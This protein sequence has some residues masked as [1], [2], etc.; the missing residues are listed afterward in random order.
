[1]ATPTQTLNSSDFLKL[2]EMIKTQFS[3]I[4]NQLNEILKK[5]D[6]SSTHSSRK[7]KTDNST[8]KREKNNYDTIKIFPIGNND[9]N[10]NVLF[11]SEGDVIADVYEISVDEL[12]DKYVKSQKE[13]TKSVSFKNYVKTNIQAVLVDG[14]EW[15][16]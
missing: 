12:M 1:M 15:D 2:E 9:K 10:A 3:N 6:N 11:L 7:N 16:F 8:E 4:E 14:G 13:H 5:M